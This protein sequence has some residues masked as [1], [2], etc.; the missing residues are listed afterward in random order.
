M[1]ETPGRRAFIG[2][3]PR[4]LLGR[5]SVN[6]TRQSKIDEPLVAFSQ[7]IKAIRAALAAGLASPHVA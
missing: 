7:D 3:L 2:P 5:N 1:L 4:L 6:F